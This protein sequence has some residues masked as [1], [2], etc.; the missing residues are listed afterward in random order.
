MNY[1]D[2]LQN[3]LNW[4][5]QDDDD[6]SRLDSMTFEVEGITE[7]ATIV[8]EPSTTTDSVIVSKEVASTET[9]LSSDGSE[10]TIIPGLKDMY[11]YAIA[12][13][14]GCALLL[15]GVFIY[16]KRRVKKGR[17][18]SI[19]NDASS[20]INEV[21]GQKGARS[22]DNSTMET[23]TTEGQNVITSGLLG[24]L[25]RLAGKESEDGDATAGSS[26][27][28]NN[29]KFIKVVAPSGKLGLVVSSSPDK[30]TMPMIVQLKNKSVLAGKAKVGDLLLLVDEVDCRGMT[31]LEVSNLIAS[32]SQQ[33]ERVFVLSRG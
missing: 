22:D 9:E 31:A 24:F 16:W 21:A 29:N 10:A 18:V 1:L 14:A 30:D 7:E 28:D 32:R 4:H 8:D 11:F 27:D 26:S 13:A 23:P 19:E 17:S 5:D 15:L 6:G 3:Q 20:P 33:P 25:S 2:S 12:I